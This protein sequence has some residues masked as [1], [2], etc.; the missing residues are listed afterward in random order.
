MFPHDLPP[1]GAQTRIQKIGKKLTAQSRGG[2]PIRNG[3]GKKKNQ[4]PF[5]T[6]QIEK[7]KMGDEEEDEASSPVPGIRHKTI[8]KSYRSRY[9]FHPPSAAEMDEGPWYPTIK[10]GVPDKENGIMLLN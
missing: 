8:S 3:K 6:L 9:R 5:D 4:T 10:L 2:S 1:S 7:L